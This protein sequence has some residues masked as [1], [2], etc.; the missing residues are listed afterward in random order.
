MRTRFLIE[1]EDWEAR[2]EGQPFRKSLLAGMNK[3][4]IE[5][6]LRQDHGWLDCRWEQQWNCGLG[7]LT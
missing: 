7:E 1:N 3:K 6:Q 5:Q 4:T 2:V